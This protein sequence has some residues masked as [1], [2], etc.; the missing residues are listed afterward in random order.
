MP[1][2]F[3]RFAKIEQE[4]AL[5]AETGIP[6][7]FRLV[8][9]KILSPTEAIINGRH[10]YLVG[11]YNYMGLTFDPD[12][13]QAGKDALD[14]FGSGTTGSRTLN[15]TYGLHVKLEE[16]IADFYATKDAMIFSTGYQA[17]LAMCSTLAGSKDYI[18]LDADSHASIY[19]GC[20]LGSAQIVRF[21]HND[22]DDLEKRLRRLP[23]AAGKLVIIEGVYSMLGDMARMKDLVAASKAHDAMIMDDEAHAM[24]IF[25]EHGRGVLEEAGVE[26][27]IDFVVGTFSKSLGTIGGYCASNHP[28]FDLLRYICR[29][30]MFTASLPPSVIAT[31]QAALAKIRADKKSRHHLLRM[32]QKLHS[33][34]RIMG[35]ET[36]TA[37]AQSAIIALIMPSQEAAVML[38]NGLL[39]SGVYVNVAR[40]PATPQGMVLV[41]MSLCAQHSE[42]VVDKVLSAF[43]KVGTALG[44]LSQ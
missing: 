37:E 39:E 7:P 28:K 33:G 25:G 13:L 35:Y 27:E 17:N 42:E 8:M 1:D 6:D 4:R 11:T 41:R 44:L 26:N 16:E 22:P 12:V 20:S 15:G 2:L 30:Y 5:L 23:S 3:D 32:S 43:Q 36:A 40:P 34:L 18:I 19:D 14:A 31:A 29:P 21:R 10:T 38:W 24:G 9:E